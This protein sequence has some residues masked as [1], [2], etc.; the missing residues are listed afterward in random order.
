MTC[1]ATEALATAVFLCDGG[2]RV[3]NLTP[4]AEAMVAGPGPLVLEAQILACRSAE[5]TSALLAA[6]DVV[7][8]NS[9]G[10]ASSIAVRNQC[11]C[12]LFLDITA[13]P[14]LAGMLTAMSYVIVAIRLPR[15]PMLARA[16]ARQL[17]LTEAEAEVARALAQGEERLSIARRRGV[18]LG[19]IRA[20]LKGI[21]VKLGVSREAELIAK[22][23][24]VSS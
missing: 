14:P 22:I 23:Y 11:G 8:R 9:G 19:T 3:Q 4:S 7:A 12:L 21:F 15:P 24:Q 5:G 10:P 17:G 6:I 2:G 18:S 20:Q 1:A 16:L 13:L